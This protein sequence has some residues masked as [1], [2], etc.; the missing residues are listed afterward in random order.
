MADRLKALFDN[1]RTE[2]FEYNG[3]KITVREELGID[4]LDQQV[5]RRATRDKWYED[6]EGVYPIPDLVWNRIINAVG[7]LARTV[8]VVG[9]LPGGLKLPDMEDTD[10]LYEAFWAFLTLPNDL[11]LKW[12]AALSK[13]NR[14][15]PTPE[16][17]PG[18]D[19]NTTSS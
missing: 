3:A 6:H 19:K 18:D 15:T 16:A 7:Y 13:V 1:A 8:K 2:T 12:D 14:P 4:Q 5:Y 17:P 10:G 9:K 11:I